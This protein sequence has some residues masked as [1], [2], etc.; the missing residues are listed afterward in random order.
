[1]AYSRRVRAFTL[2]EAAAVLGL[3]GV[4]AALATATFR[5]LTSRSTDARNALS[6]GEFVDAGFPSGFDRTG[7]AVSFTRSVAQVAA[8]WMRSAAASG[9]AVRSEAVAVSDPAWGL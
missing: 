5:E 1:M 3:L 9:W 6:L 2:L 4:V 8:A 7:G